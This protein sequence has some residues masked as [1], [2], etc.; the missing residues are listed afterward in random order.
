MNIAFESE[1]LND[2]DTNIKMHMTWMEG[3]KALCKMSTVYNGAVDATTLYIRLG[4]K[5]I[6]AY[7]ISTSNWSKLPNCPTR[8]CPLVIVNSLF[9]LVGGDRGSITNQLFSLTGEGSGRRWTEEFSPMPT[10]RSGTTALCN[11]AVLIIAGGMN[12]DLFLLQTVEIMSTETL[13]WS[14][15]VHLPEPTSFAPGA[16]CGD[17]FYILGKSSMYSCSEIALVQ[18]R[19]SFLPNL[20]KRDTRVWK[21]V[22]SSPVRHTSCVSFH[23]QLL[24]IGG[25]DSN[26]ATTTA[27]HLYK[28]TTDSWEIISHMAIARRDC[29]AAVLPNN[30]LM[31]VGGRTDNGETDSVEFANSQTVTSKQT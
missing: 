14:T 3:Y 13:Q 26:G 10:K 9:T 20:R 6:Y 17:Q 7:T 4:D 5:D 25:R 22:S 31:V 23:G 1:Q 16:V 11:G 18:S 24:T 27:I 12:L 19:K 28:P 15:T 21:K 29:I 30:Q 8:S 2:R